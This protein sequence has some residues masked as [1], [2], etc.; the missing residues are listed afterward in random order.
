MRIGEQG[1][2]KKTTR[3]EVRRQKRNE[4]G[5]IVGMNCETHG[6]DRDVEWRVSGL[7]TTDDVRW[8]LAFRVLVKM[9]TES[10][11]AAIVRDE[12]LGMSRRE[13]PRRR[14]EAAVRQWL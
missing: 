2:R 13:E 14:T 3:R 12:R 10:C 6:E 9:A 1:R 4:D 11:G 8:R 7:K 5:K